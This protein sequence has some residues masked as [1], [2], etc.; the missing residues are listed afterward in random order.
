M[1]PPRKF[2]LLPAAVALAVAVGAGAP[3]A[4]AAKMP[5]ITAKYTFLVSVK[6]TQKTTWT[7]DHVGQGSCDG[8][9][10][11]SG[12][13]VVKFSSAAKKMHTF[14]G[15][16]QPYFFTKTKGGAGQLSLPL[17]GKVT[18]NGSMTVPV[19]ADPMACPDGVGGPPPSPDCGTKAF[20]KGIVVSPKYEYGKPRIVLEQKDAYNVPELFK[21]CPE[22]G[23][24]FPYLLK[25]DTAGETVGQSLPYDDLFAHGKHI[26]IASATYKK[27]DG[28]SKWTTTIRWELTLK[29]I[30]KE[31]LGD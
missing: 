11:G 29:R 3:T 14:D 8:N 23:D 26:L 15:L 5:K 24:P 13:Q 1:V 30:K 27:S 17:K 10:H 12:K 20:S 19:P 21:H 25:E 4:G 18:R 22:G 6:G 2:L 28:E 9:Q 7:Y 16:S 31:K